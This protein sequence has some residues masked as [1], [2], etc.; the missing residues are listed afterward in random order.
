MPNAAVLKEKQEIVAQL[1]EKMKNAS[2]G[3]L[4][5]YKGITVANDTKLRRELRNAGVEYSV[6]KNTLTKLAADQ[7]GFSEIDEHLNG[8]TAIAI[9]PS[10]PI[11]AAKI[12]HNYAKDS[13]GAFSIKVGFVD[14]Q[15]ISA[16]EVEELATIPSREGL[17]TKLLYCLT[18]GP[19]SLAIALN[20]LAEKNTEGTAEAAEALAEA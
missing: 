1:A 14:G 4:V 13:N 15:V 6:V 8:T 12:L 3:V 2:A 7:I 10:D 19:R 16:A 17:L 5:D 18:N 20:A 9:I 11:A